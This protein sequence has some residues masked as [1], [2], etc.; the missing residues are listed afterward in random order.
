M[1]YRPAE[2][3]AALRKYRERRYEQLVDAVYQ[4]RGWDQKWH[5]DTGDCPPAGDRFPGCDGIDSQKP[6]IKRHIWAVQ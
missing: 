1:V 6:E 2:K 3:M 5:P 4:R